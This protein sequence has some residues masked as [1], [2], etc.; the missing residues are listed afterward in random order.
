MDTEEQTNAAEGGATESMQHTGHN[1]HDDDDEINQLF[2]QSDDEEDDDD[3]V[4]APGR[5]QQQGS[6]NE[7]QTEETGLEASS[8]S[9]S[10]GDNDNDDENQGG[11]RK[12]LRK[13]KIK[14][15][16]KPQESPETPE[17]SKKKGKKRL[18]KAN[19]EQGTE[20]RSR[21]KRA[22]KAT[23]S[24]D[25]D[26]PNHQENKDGDESDEYDEQDEGPMT[27]EDEEFIDTRDDDQ[28]LLKEYGEMNQQFNDERPSSQRRRG[29]GVEHEGEGDWVAD[30]NEDVSE[31]VRQIR[32]MGT[33]K[34]AKSKRKEWT[35]EEKEAFVKNVFDQMLSAAQEDRENREQQ[36][37][38]LRKLKLLPVS[39]QCVTL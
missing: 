37:T 6:Q 38:A 15:Q 35:N 27:K 23:S 14:K 13:R 16:S 3:V 4:G 24:E 8:S 25:E 32:N 11:G 22:K 39:A 36:R 21:R 30:P 29:D 34:S 31:E 18:K 7:Q 20:S 28:E 9:D 33:R 2:A 5:Q 10:E 17:T 19:Q 26:E 1:D 12:R